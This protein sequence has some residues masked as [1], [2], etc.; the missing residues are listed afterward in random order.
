MEVRK[1][2]RDELDSFREMD[3][4]SYNDIVDRV[5]IEKHNFRCPV[6]AFSMIIL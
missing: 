5:V 1:S 2:K 6:I 4:V 3:K